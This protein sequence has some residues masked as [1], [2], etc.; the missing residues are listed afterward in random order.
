MNVPCLFK[1]EVGFHFPH[2][3]EIEHFFR[4]DL[5]SIVTCI[6]YSVVVVI[7]EQADIVF[8]SWLQEVEVA[9]LLVADGLLAYDGIG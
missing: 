6:P 7:I 5:V 9:C 3:G 4:L 1:L 8:G 2:F